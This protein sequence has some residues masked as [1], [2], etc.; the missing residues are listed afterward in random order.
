M[1]VLCQDNFRFLA[2]LVP[3]MPPYDAPVTFLDA[4][5]NIGLASILFAHI[6]GA[7]G[8]VL[9]VEALPNTA[10]LTEI[11]TAHL[12]NTV[13]VVRGALVSEARGS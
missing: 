8:Q 6:L 9:A 10:N 11:N 1:Q 3:F 12:R 5:A 4:G 7:L 2:R 13:T